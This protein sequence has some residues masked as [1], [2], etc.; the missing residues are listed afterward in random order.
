MPVGV[1]LGTHSNANIGVCQVQPKL[2]TIDLEIWKENLIKLG[3]TAGETSSV[4][5]A[6]SSSIV[7][8]CSEIQHASDRL[9]QEAHC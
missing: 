2:A 1:A 4:A 5:A 7:T 3:L 6:L 8:E 9:S